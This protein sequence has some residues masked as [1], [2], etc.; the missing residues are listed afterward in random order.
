MDTKIGIHFGTTYDGKGS[1]QLQNGINQAGGAIARLKNSI[2]TMGSGIGLALKTVGSN[3]MNIKAGFDMLIGVVSKVGQVIKNAFDIS[4][5]ENNFKFLIGSV[6]EARRHMKMLY[7]LGRTPPFSMKE[8]AAA[9]KSL[10]V[11][12]ENA[13]GGKESLNMIGDA[14]DGVGVP[15]ETMAESIGYL[16]AMIRDGQPITRATKQLVR[17]GAIS[18]EV[19]SKMETMQKQGESLSDIWETL[20]TALTKFT[21][22]MDMTS[23]STGGKIEIMKSRFEE[24]I[25]SIT[26]SFAD[27]FESQMGKINDSLDSVANNSSWD[28][29]AN[30]VGRITGKLMDKG[31][32]LASNVAGFASNV[33]GFA[34]V[35]TTPEFNERQN[36]SQN[37]ALKNKIEEIKKPEDPVIK[38]NKVEWEN[39]NKTIEKTIKSLNELGYNYTSD[40]VKNLRDMKFKALDGMNIGSKPEGVKI[41]MEDLKS[42]VDSWSGIKK[43]SEKLTVDQEKIATNNRKAVEEEIRAQDEAAK[44]ESKAYY[45][46]EMESRENLRNTLLTQIRNRLENIHDQQKKQ[47]FYIDASNGG[48][49]GINDWGK[50]N[51]PTDENGNFLRPEHAA[52][53]ERDA[54]RGERN[55]NSQRIGPNRLAAMQKDYNDLKNKIAKNPAGVEGLDDRDRKRFRTLDKFFNPEEDKLNKAADQ[56]KKQDL[57]QINTTL[58]NIKTMLEQSLNIK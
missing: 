16:Y 52:E 19:A 15:I 1:R 11:L 14:A 28:K 35:K 5:L 8:F 13:L 2:K 50:G 47:K 45:D 46:Q 12:S 34:G 54:G 20:T 32:T 58:D 38:L 33:L 26:V 22:A 10:M 23:E 39:L 37:E 21:G 9:S 31:A 3:L 49:D 41:M 48:N 6:D 30:Q 51:R 36:A 55:I 42:M 7:E 29:L 18:P 57:T 40:D 17:M 25:N 56:I 44:N 27:G 53:A 43:A 4:R 24:F